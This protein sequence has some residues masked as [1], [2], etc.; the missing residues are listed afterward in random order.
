RLALGHVLAALLA[1]RADGDLFRPL[2]LGHDNFVNFTTHAVIVGRSRRP[3]HVRPADEDRPES[4]GRDDVKLIPCPYDLP[5][6]FMHQPVMEMADRGEPG[7]R[8]RPARPGPRTQDGGE[9]TS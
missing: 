1:P 9:S 4:L 2:Q 3:S 8:G 7:C 5:F 6:P